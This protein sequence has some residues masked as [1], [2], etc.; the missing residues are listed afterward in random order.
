MLIKSLIVV[1]IQNHNISDVIRSGYWKM[2]AISILIVYSGVFYFIHIISSL[3]YAE[4]FDRYRNERV[5]S[6]AICFTKINKN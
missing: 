4:I 5:K 1:V 2:N 3:I 6:S